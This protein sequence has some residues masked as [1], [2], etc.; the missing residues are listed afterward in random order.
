MAVSALW[1]RMTL[2]DRLLLFVLLALILITLPVTRSQGKGARLLVEQDGAVLYAAPLTASG[3]WRFQG[4]LGESEIEVAHGGARIV[5]SPCPHKL[6]I[7]L[8]RIAHPGELIACVPNHLLL[9]IE[10]ESAS[11]HDLITR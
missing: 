4:P 3:R 5:S 11:S 10:G 1:R 2:G 8:G 7:A 6:C 9:R